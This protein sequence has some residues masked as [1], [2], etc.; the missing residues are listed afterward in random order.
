MHT[1]SFLDNLIN[2]VDCA[3]RTLIPPKKRIATRSSP[4][5]ALADHPLSTAKKNTLRV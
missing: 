4:A 1:N 5:D 2:E 3:L